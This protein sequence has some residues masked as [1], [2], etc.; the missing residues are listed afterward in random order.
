M[1]AEMLQTHPLPFQSPTTPLLNLMSHFAN[2]PAGKPDA[3]LHLNTLFAADTDPRKVSLGVGA[4]RDENGKPWILPSV[5]KAEEIISSDFAKYNKEYP[6]QPGFPMFIKSA[7]EFLLGED[8]PAIAEKRVATCQSLS[9]TG[10]LHVGFCFLHQ[11]YSGHPVYMPSVTWPNHYGVYDEVYHGEKY[12]E[13]T[14]LCRDGSLKIDFEATKKDMRDAPYGSIFLLHA[15]AHNPSG[16]DFTK[17]QWIEIKDIFKEKKHIAFFDI[18]YQGFATGSFEEDG[19]APRF[20]AREGCEIIVAQSFSKNFGLYGERVGACHVVHNE[21]N[22]EQ[23][24]K[25]IQAA[26]C[27]TVRRTW[28]MSPIHGAYIVMT[29]GQNPELKKQFLEDVKT[30][31]ARIKKMR[32]MLY[33]ELVRIGAPGDWSHIIKCIG[34]FTFTGL[35]PA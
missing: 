32:Q 34:M 9:G 30:M 14:Y 8:H 3:I 15:C 16:I 17:E 27:L 21:K 22:N 25:N 19:F 13:Y 1:R 18:A 10:S 29:I 31:A 2:V 6:P 4:Y 33:D 7:Q 23:L 28:S 20:F 35:T 12:K 11:F 24:S 5:R 26:M